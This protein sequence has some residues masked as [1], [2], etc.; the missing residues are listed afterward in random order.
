MALL[1]R[2]FGGQALMIPG[3][4]IKI[5]AI[6]FFLGGLIPS[7]FWL[8]FWL[9]EDEEHPEP[10]ILLA[11]VFA[12]GIA[13]VI[14][15]LPIQKFINAH[16]GSYEGKLALWAAAEEAL[17]YLAV[18]AVLYRT[19]NADHPVDWPIYM[20][21]AALGFATLENT[22]FLVKP[23]ALSGATV[24]LL[25]GSLRFLGSTLLHTVASASLGIAIGASMFM[26]KLKRFCFRFGGFIVA[27][28]LHT[29]FNFFIMKEGGDNFLKVFSFLWAATII[30]LLLFEKIRRLSN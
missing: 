16:I 17:K 3:G 14:L 20:I 25:T 7:L 27:V 1:R 12:M 4:D 2:G 19:H 22:L 18:L 29:A 30:V 6:A 13:T 11:I 9:K 10:A 5:F 24:T 21:T 28:V 15:V 8:W 23:L 26:G